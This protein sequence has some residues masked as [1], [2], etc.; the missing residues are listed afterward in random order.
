MTR[1]D[2]RVIPDA[3][4]CYGIRLAFLLGMLTGLLMGAC[5][6]L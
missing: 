3:E 4:P 1:T 6:I 2:P 5:C